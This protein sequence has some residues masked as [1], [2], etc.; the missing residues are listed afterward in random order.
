MVDE[1]KEE[2]TENLDTNSENIVEEKIE[3]VLSQEDISSSGQVDGEQKLA[4]VNENDDVIK[5]GQEPIKVGRRVITGGI[6]GL[7]Q[8]AVMKNCTRSNSRLKQ[9]L[10]GVIQL[11]VTGTGSYVL[12]WRENDMTIK[13][14]A[15]ENADCTIDMSSSDFVD[16]A[17]G[18]LN[19]QI[20]ILSDKVKFKGRAE[21]ASYLF[22]I[23][24]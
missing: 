3:Q 15:I 23:F 6:M 17:N 1:V 5:S 7:L 24:S 2:I 21:M 12:D 18:D 20:A 9:H 4:D 10:T 11:N 14:G 19:I 13:E 8:N 16:A 22:N